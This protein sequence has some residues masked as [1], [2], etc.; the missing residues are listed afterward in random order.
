[1]FRRGTF[2]AGVLSYW[3][4]VLGSRSRVSGLV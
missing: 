1:M 2:G 3:D 4:L